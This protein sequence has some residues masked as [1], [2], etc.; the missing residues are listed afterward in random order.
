MTAFERTISS[1]DVD[2]NL[3]RVALRQLAGAVSVITAGAGDTRA[4]LT[5]TSVTSF[6]AEPPTILVSVNTSASAYPTIVARRHFA[7]NILSH[8]QQAIADRFAG[9]LGLKGADRYQGAEWR[10]LASGAPALVGALAV[11]DAQIEEIIERHSH[12]IL[13]GR[14]KA[15]EADTQTG[16]LLYWRGAYERFLQS[17][18]AGDGI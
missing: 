10:T 14:V 5:A 11:I 16:A 4:G 3:F 13:I 2:A 6:S 15:V 12:A 8:E 17:P 18:Q 9:R 7:V 1:L